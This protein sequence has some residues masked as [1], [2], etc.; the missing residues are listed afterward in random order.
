MHIAFRGIVAKDPIDDNSHFAIS[1]PSVG[2]EP[3][4]R[5]H[6][7]GGHEEDGR[8]SDGESDE[9]LDQEKPVS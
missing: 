7:R 9:T 6:C 5:R 4:L 1:K 3:C 8:Y 2:A